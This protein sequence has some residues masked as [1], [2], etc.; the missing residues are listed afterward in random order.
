MSHKT[1]SAMRMSF[2]GLEAQSAKHQMHFDSV[3][4]NSVPGISTDNRNP[5]T[6]HFSFN[7]RLFMSA[8]FNPSIVLVIVTQAA[9][10]DRIT[11]D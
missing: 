6:V 5:S 3:H 1:L 8:V 9:I 10:G 2:S 4:S 11:H 7:L